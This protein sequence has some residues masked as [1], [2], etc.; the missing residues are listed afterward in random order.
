[1]KPRNPRNFGKEFARGAG[2]LGFGRRDFM[3]CEAATGPRFSMPAFQSTPSRGRGAKLG[4]N[5]LCSQPVLDASDAKCLIPQ[6][7]KGGRVV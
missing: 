2:L 6:Q 7:R 4:P 3:I 5:G 1:M